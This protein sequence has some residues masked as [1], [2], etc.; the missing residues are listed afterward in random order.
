M[1]AD[2]LHGHRDLGA[3]MDSEKMVTAKDCLCQATDR[4]LLLTTSV[5]KLCKLCHI[6]V[7]NCITLRNLQLRHPHTD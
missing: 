2:K 6:V 5:L 4:I 7:G 1:C 3:E